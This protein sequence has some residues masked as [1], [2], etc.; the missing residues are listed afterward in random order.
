[1][2][3]KASAN[4]ATTSAP[5]AIASPTRNCFDPASSGWRSSIH[6]IDDAI[7][8]EARNQIVMPIVSPAM[9]AKMYKCET[10][11]RSGRSLS[12]S[13]SVEGRVSPVDSRDAAARRVDPV[14]IP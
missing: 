4:V 6:V 3:Q 7:Q 14:R 13:T 5:Q 12:Q 9:I 2:I 1:M 10:Q 8:W 11:I